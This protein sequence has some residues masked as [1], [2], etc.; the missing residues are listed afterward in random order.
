MIHARKRHLVACMLAWLAQ[1]ETASGQVPVAGI[2]GTPPIVSLGAPRVIAVSGAAPSVSPQYQVPEPRRFD[3][4]IMPVGVNTVAGPS[5]VQQQPV[6]IVAQ[7][8]I[9]RAHV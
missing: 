8:E 7:P 1:W 4:A 6:G 3:Q 9:G 5:L 2:P